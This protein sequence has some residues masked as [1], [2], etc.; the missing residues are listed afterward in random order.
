MGKA[1]SIKN[2]ISKGVDEA[3]SRASSKSNPDK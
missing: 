3:T 1:N 2:K